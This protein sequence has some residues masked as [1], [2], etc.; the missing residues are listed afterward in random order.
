MS[1]QAN[2]QI[3]LEI[4]HVLF[5]DIVGYSKLSTSEQRRAI[6]TLNEVVRSSG[7]IQKAEPTNR[8]IKIPTGDGM[9]LVFYASPEA[10]AC[11]A[12]ELSHA[13]KKDP[14]LA[15]RMGVHSGPVSGVIDVNGRANLAGAGL[16]IAQRIM[17]C[18]DGGHILV[19]KHAADDLKEYEQW[20]PLL[21]ELGVFEVKHGVKLH[22]V[23]LCG[24]EIGNGRV[25]TKL[26]VQRQRIARR[27]MGLAAVALVLAAMALFWN[28]ASRRAQQAA[29]SP[30][31]N[32]VAV[33]PF[34][35]LLADSD[36]QILEIGM[37]DTLITKLSNTR[38]MIVP[39]LTSVRPYA[40]TTQDP[41]AAGRRLG[42]SSV[43]EGTVQKAGDRLRVSARLIKVAD[44]SSLW[45][46][47]F[48]E[49]IADVF[50]IQDK[51][52]QKVVEALTL[53]LSGEGQERL[54]KRYTE[55]I[56]AYQLYLTGR[57]HWNKLTPPEIGK[58][59]GFF[60][61]AVELDPNYAL[62]YF[63][64]A[65]AYRALAITSDMPAREVFPQA[66][67]AAEKALQIDDSL[68]E[69]HATLVLI[70]T[71][72]D[73]DWASAEKEARRGISLNPNSG[74]CHWAYA[75]LLSR[76]SR[77]DEA[78]AEGARARGLDPT[79]LITNAHEG[80]VL[81]FARRYDEATER[82][83]KTLDLGPTFWVAHLFL[84]Q[85]YLQKKKF[86]EALAA[87]T[88]AK[89]FSRGNSEAI[90]M[91]GYTQARAGDAAKAQTTLD[92]L[93]SLSA[94]HYVPPYNMAVL[95]IGLGDQENAIAWLDKACD[96]RDVRF[97]FLK[98]DPKWD[99]FRS[100]PRVVAILKRIGLP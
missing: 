48:D 86:P 19:S 42:V 85:V 89:E 50:A 70:H 29:F 61:K 79:S 44:G 24:E 23:N 43:L 71:W 12:V 16:N 36:D 68:A 73:W 54:T 65:D 92:E 82:L 78:I 2:K 94:Q 26:R 100:D 47:M 45:A 60:Q 14:H 69:P 90:S 91:I 93:K 87:F 77:H 35:P 13:L 28:S 7:Q 20:R 18:G 49:K 52:S 46:A 3:A 41:L 88:K 25:P 55:N 21:H 67:A 11:C 57:Y 34:K 38:E 6:D 9:A 30:S 5:V 15:V 37:A 51:I 84:G 75:D 62:A 99:L 22:V 63:G 72:F 59:I 97:S 74:F 8:L 56:D 83:Q 96:D 33:L 4:A 64:L 32:S 66:K 27:W 81:Y 58:S 76:L 10:P 80:A 95:Y 1:E 40:G 53:R 17:D 98:I 39:S 31:A